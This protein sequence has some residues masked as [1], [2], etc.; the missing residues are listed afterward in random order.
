MRQRALEM[1]PHRWLGL[2]EKVIGSGARESFDI[3]LGLHDHE[4][5]IQRLLGEAS[6]G[7]HDDR[8]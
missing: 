1:H 5:D 4:M 2:Y 8:G 6:D 3:A 7:F